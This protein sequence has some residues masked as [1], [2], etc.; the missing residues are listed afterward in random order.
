MTSALDVAQ[1]CCGGNWELQQA[2]IKAMVQESHCSTLKGGAED[3]T[4]NDRI[5]SHAVSCQIGLG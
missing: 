2:L 4:V 5:T 3:K 1:S